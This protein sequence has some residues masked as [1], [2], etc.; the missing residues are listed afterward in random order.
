MA[1]HRSNPMMF[2]PL[3][4]DWEG[5]RISLLRADPKGLN[6]TQAGRSIATALFHA[7]TPA[8]WA[9]LAAEVK[10]LSLDGEQ[11]TR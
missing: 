7:L 4:P 9:G 6:P 5:D 8:A 3:R 11:D 1:D 10:R 2:A